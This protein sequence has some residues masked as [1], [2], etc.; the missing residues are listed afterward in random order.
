MDC[1]FLKFLCRL[2]DLVIWDCRLGFSRPNYRYY[3]LERLGGQDYG[4]NPKNGLKHHLFEFVFA[5]FSSLDAIITYFRSQIRI[6]GQ[7]LPTIQILR[8]KGLPLGQHIE[9]HM[10]CSTKLSLQDPFMGL[11]PPKGKHSV[12]FLNIGL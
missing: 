1:V 4:E 9:K 7:T 2:K 11:N 6:L 12:F 3:Q 5:I 8:S 10:I